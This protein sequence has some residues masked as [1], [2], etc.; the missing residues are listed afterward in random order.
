MPESPPLDKEA[1]LNESQAMGGALGAIAFGVLRGI[2]AGG[3]DERL[4]ASMRVL[5][6]EHL[7][8]LSD[9]DCN[10]LCDVVYQRLQEEE[11][12]DNRWY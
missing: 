4:V 5:L 10:T 8:K 7:T 9:E 1:L 2:Q 6:H 3:A 12:K 11:R